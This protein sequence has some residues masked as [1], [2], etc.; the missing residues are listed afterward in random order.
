LIHYFYGLEYKLNEPY[1]YNSYLENNLGGEPFPA[2]VVFKLTSINP[3]KDRAKFIAIHTPEPTEYKRIIYETY[4]NM[5]AQMELP[6]PDKKEFETAGTT[7]NYEAEVSIAE[8]WPVSVKV[9]KLTNV[10]DTKST[11]VTTIT[12][13]K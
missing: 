1:S 12:L 13:I 5:A 3:A 9:T 2:K 4:S 6:L 8:G 10:Q 7:H 11:E